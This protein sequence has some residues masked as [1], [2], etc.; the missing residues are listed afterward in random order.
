TYTTTAEPLPTAPWLSPTD[1]PTYGPEDDLH[2]DDLHPDD[3]APD[4]PI[5]D[6]LD[7][8]QMQA[9]LPDDPGPDPDWSTDLIL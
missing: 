3:L 1:L 6:D 2:P 4:D 5:L 7:D 8:H 9:E